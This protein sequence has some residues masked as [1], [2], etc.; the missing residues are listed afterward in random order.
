MTWPE[1]KLPSWDSPLSEAE[2]EDEEL[3]LNDL[4]RDNCVPETWGLSVVAA[5]LDGTIKTFHNF[6]FPVRL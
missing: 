1:E 3:C 4:Y 2:F 6:G 5:G